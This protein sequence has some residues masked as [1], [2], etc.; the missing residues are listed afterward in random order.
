MAGTAQSFFNGPVG[1]IQNSPLGIFSL[2]AIGAGNSG[3]VH[4]S[5]NTVVR[6]V[7]LDY[8]A[9]STVTSQ[10]RGFVSILRTQN[11]VFT[12][13]FV[14]H[15]IA[16]QTVTGASS[17]ITNVMGFYASNNIVATASAVT[18]FFSDI[19]SAAGVRQFYASGT[20]DSQFNGAIV[21][22]NSPIINSRQV[23]IYSASM[24]P[25][26]ASGNMDVITISGA[27]AHTIN[28]PGTA[29]TGQRLII[30]L[31]HA[32]GGSAGA[33]TWNAIFKMTAW[34]QP[35]DG[36]SRTIEF[37]YD[38]SNWIEIDRTTADVPN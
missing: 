24:T 14:V 1:I 20:G 6:G 19:N 15:F 12:S 7:Q 2:L 23:M 27:V 21:L 10:Q 17:I 31:R 32:S 22:S 26:A 25:A 29:R 8:M 33:A 18:G 34:V 36:F 35:A 4:P 37:V 9:A 28:S 30:T 13:G 38:G 16:D 5:T 11:A 3:I